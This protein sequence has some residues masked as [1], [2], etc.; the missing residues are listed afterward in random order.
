MKKTKLS[1]FTLFEFIELSCGNYDVLDDDA[2]KD[3]S[4]ASTAR[5]ILSEY[6]MI[7][8]SAHA[9]A[10]ISERERE[11][12]CSANIMI[13]NL[14]SSLIRLGDKEKAKDILNDI[15][16]SYGEDI[17]ISVENMLR[18]AKFEYERSKSGLES[19]LRRTPDEIRAS[20]FSEIAFI[21][22]YYKMNINEREINAHVYANL[23]RQVCDEIRRRQTIK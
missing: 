8:D 22:S 14:C 6:S 9:K 1:D 23:V 7:A 17:G 2:S 20:F 16:A 13:L 3:E 21:M 15:G 4:R 19:K 5:D 18:Y 12:K 10:I 11:M